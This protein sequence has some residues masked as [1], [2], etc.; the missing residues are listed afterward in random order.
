M[1]TRLAFLGLAAL[2]SLRCIDAAPVEKTVSASRQFIVY[3]TDRRVRGA[4]CD[5]AERAKR[6]FL[7]LLR[8]RDAWRTP[9]VIHAESRQADLPD[10]PFANLR[11][12]Q[13]GFGLKLQLDL[14]VGAAAN[15]EEV[16]RE[17]LRAILLELMYRGASETP[18]GTAYVQPPDWLVYGIQ[19]LAPEHELSSTRL[20]DANQA[21]TLEQV[22]TQNPALLEA[23]LRQVYRADAAALVSTLL[24]LSD[25]RT[26]LAKMLA[27]AP[28]ATADPMTNLTSY[29]AELG[30]TETDRGERW[31]HLLARFAT[32]S[33]QRMLSC[34]ETERALAT[35]LS[36]AVPSASDASKRYGLDEF[37]TFVGTRAA[38][39]PLKQLDA[40]L[41]ELS[42]RANQ[43]YAPTIAEYRRITLALLRRKTNHLTDR[44]AR[45][46]GDREEL[47][48]RMDT[49]ADYLNWFEATQARTA[50]G[51][52]ADYAQSAERVAKRQSHRRDP[53]SLYLDALAAQLGD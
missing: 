44:L 29:F 16:E 17:L 10:A 53:I 42:G 13:T 43:L 36:A 39:E 21:M 25:G 37:P 15:S 18:A 22:V 6:N 49:I 12:S 52:F 34:E 51:A 3:G 11:V 9:L 2:A 26:R 46:R 5:V 20:A 31:K 48:R 28:R 7:T 50:S 24:E 38:V 40:Q 27:D 41:L 32:R 47:N 30:D 1:K 4:I 19:A 23:P 14:S 45:L 8:Q 35:L 33:Q